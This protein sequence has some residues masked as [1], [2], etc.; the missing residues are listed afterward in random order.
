MVILSPD[1]GTEE[2]HG[3]IHTSSMKEEAI[4]LL[5]LELAKLIAKSVLRTWRK[6]SYKIKAKP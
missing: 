4:G 3:T 5:T 1:D 2:T 6:L